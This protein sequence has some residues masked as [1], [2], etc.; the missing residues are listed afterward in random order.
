MPDAPGAGN[1]AAS[2][3]GMGCSGIEMTIFEVVIS[4]NIAGHVGG[5][6][7]NSNACGAYCKKHQRKW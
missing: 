2:D 4:G 6:I 5:A 7:G 1:N 3:S